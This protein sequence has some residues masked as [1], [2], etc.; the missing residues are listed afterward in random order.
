M[1]EFRGIHQG[2][3]TV[4]GKAMLIDGIINGDL[5]IEGGSQVQFDGVVRGSVQLQGGS[6]YLRGIVKNNVDNDGGKLTIRGLV[7]GRVR[8][9]TG[10]TVMEEGS[11]VGRGMR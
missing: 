9:H 1:E 3:L 5:K 8:T 2:T 7:K 11:L 10:E 6:L 4:H